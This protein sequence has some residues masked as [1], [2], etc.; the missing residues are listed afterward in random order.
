LE[1]NPGEHD[2]LPVA[3]AIKGIFAELVANHKSDLLRLRTMLV[4][5]RIQQLK[6]ESSETDCRFDKGQLH[7]MLGVLQQ[8]QNIL[9]FSKPVLDANYPTEEVGLDLVN[10]VWSSKNVVSE[11][12]ELTTRCHNAVQNVIAHL[13]FVA[14]SG[15]EGKLEMPSATF[16]ALCAEPEAPVEATG[17]AEWLEAALHA[18]ADHVADP[19]VEDATRLQGLYSSFCDQLRADEPDPEELYADLRGI[20]EVL[21]RL[22][23]R[24]CEILNRM[25][26]LLKMVARLD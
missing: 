7:E 16:T 1:L 17:A 5:E 6:E 15:S 11:L 2:H 25:D 19:A 10:N 12:I 21:P 23:D 14:G 8:M 9:S 4:R 24:T 26:R 22:E 13:D 20:V 18:L 3:S